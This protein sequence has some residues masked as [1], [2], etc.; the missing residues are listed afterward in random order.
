M[1][2]SF[3]MAMDKN[4]YTEVGKIVKAIDTI[5]SNLKIVVEETKIICQ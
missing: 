4:A 1:F 2:S 5:I 3:E